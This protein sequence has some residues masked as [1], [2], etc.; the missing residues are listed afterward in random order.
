MNAEHAVRVFKALGDPTRYRI[1]CALLARGEMGC[2][3]LSEL[4]PLSSPA[5]SH[6]YRVLENAGLL[7]SRK[8]GTSVYWCVNEETLERF[9][10]G[11]RQAHL[12]PER[13]ELI[14]TATSTKEA[15]A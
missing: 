9:L 2:A 5:L 11:F 1:V 6:H 10:P 7:R 8:E 4:F 15:S 13:A 12:V 14:L 3:E